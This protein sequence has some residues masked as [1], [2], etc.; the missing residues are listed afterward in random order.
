M[1]N[2]LF[3][4]EILS[5]GL[6]AAGDNP[7]AEVVIYKSRDFDKHA[8]PGSIDARVDLVRRAYSDKFVSGDGPQPWVSS[9]FETFVIVEDGD[10]TLRISYSVLDDEVTFGIPEQVDLETTI[11]GKMLEADTY[12]RKFSTEQREALADKGQALP[13]GSFPIVNKGD[14]R[15]AISAFGLSSNKTAARRHIIKRA[16]A[17]GAVEMLPEG[18]DVSKMTVSVE[19]APTEPGVRMDLSAIEDQDLRKSIEDAIAE[20]DTKISGLEAEVEKVEVDP[21]DDASDEVKAILKEQADELE[22]VRVDLAKERTAR[23]NAEYIEKAKPLEALLGKADDMGPVLAEL[24]EAAPEAFAKLEAPLTAATQRK[25]L[26]ALFSELGAGETEGES[27]PISKRDSWVKENQKDSES[28]EQAN[29][30][31]WKVH[32]D[33]KE[34]SRS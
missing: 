32:P 11:V 1:T 2:R 24:A 8:L 4:D 34:E 19:N 28:V 12:K 27:D 29:A 26:A 3:V 21:T 5:V 16:K 13:D 14:L 30:R 31:F 18:W 6:V 20:K 10:D 33:Q 9:V 7:D 23:R 15:N 25:E 22:K 17:L